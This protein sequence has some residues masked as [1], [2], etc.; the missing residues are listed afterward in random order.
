MSKNTLG[1]LYNHDVS[2]YRFTRQLDNHFGLEGQP[3][4][5]IWG[6]AVVLLVLLML[7]SQVL[8][9]NGVILF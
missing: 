8:R 6:K 7:L 5:K 2:H 1:R 3:K 4:P 9:Y